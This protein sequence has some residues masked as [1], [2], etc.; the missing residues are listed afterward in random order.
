MNQ[1]FLSFTFKS[2]A[3]TFLL[4]ETEQGAEIT[5]DNGQS[6]AFDQIDDVIEALEA[7]KASGAKKQGNGEGKKEDNG[8]AE[9]EEKAIS[10]GSILPPFNFNTP[11]KLAALIGKKV[12]LRDGRVDTIEYIDDGEDALAGQDEAIGLS[13][14]TWLFKDGTYWGDSR[15]SPQDIVKVLAAS[16]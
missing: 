14:G 9:K 11:E 6:I 3:P 12:E 15:E 10:S 4:F 8:E 13:D 16:N 1:T 2:D 5:I 7:I